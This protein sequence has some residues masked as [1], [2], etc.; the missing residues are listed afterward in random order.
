MGQKKSDFKYLLI[1]Q[2]KISALKTSVKTEV[3]SIFKQDK[4][5]RDRSQLQPRL[6]I[7]A[8]NI[9]KLKLLYHRY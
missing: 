8:T 4:N 6:I 2:Y 5:K 1:G 3:N 7:T 9:T